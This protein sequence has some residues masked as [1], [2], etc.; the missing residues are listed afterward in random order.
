MLNNDIAEYRIESTG[1]VLFRL[2]PAPGKQRHH[3]R[4]RALAVAMAVKGV[5]DPPGSE[6]R[7][8]HV[9]TGEVIFRMP[10]LPPASGAE[11]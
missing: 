9:P 7:V 10:A 3:F 5:T 1:T 2:T 8:V 11:T 4:D 6:I